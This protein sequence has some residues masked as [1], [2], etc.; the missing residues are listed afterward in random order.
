[1]PAV[2]YFHF[3]PAMAF[4]GALIGTGLAAAAG[5]W[6]ALRAARVA[7]AAALRGG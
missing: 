7:P 1:M 3:D 6:P 5:S 2:L 4:A